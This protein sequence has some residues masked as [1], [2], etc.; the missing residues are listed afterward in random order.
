MLFRSKKLVDG[1]IVAVSYIITQGTAAG[2]ANNFILMDTVGGYSNTAINGVVPASQGSLKETINSIKYQA[3]KAY[4]AQNR[5]V[6]KEDY[7]T[8][9]QQN[10]LGYAFDSVNVWGGEQNVPPVYGQ[11]FVCLKPSG[12]LLLTDTQKQEI[13]N[14]VIKPISV[15]TVK[16]TIINPDYIYLKIAANVLYDPKKTNLTGDQVSSV[17]TSAINNFGITTLNTFNST[18]SLSDLIVAI[19]KAD[20]S[21]ITCEVDLKVQ[22]KFYPN[23][24][25]VAN[26]N[27]YY[28]TSLQKGAFLSGI[29]STPALQYTSTTSANRSEEHTS[30]LQSH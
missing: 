6:T 25:N 10:N 19:Q 18:F 15:M 5:A 14:T 22:K 17:V 2:G 29:T 1:N 28:G 24:D 11:V 7:V 20:N 3:P 13:L 21:I 26:Y 9:I 4:A 27:L 30:E 16:P 8:L 12:A 23:L